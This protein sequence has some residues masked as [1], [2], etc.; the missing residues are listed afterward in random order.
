LVC[1]GPVSEPDKI[2][3]LKAADI[4][5]NPMFAGSGTNIKM[6]DFMALGLPTVV[7]ATGAR[8]IDPGS[9]PAFLQVGDRAQDV[10]E[11]IATLKNDPRRRQTM[12]KA[13]REWA[14]TGYAWE[15]IS[16]HLGAM[17][18]QRAKL[19][20]Q[21]RPWFSVVIP[22]FDRHAQLDQ[23]M[24]R[25][26]AQVERDFEVV[27]VD[28]S[29]DPWPGRDRPFN[30]P[31]TYFHTP[32]KGAVRA[33]NTGAALATGKILA[34][35]DDDCQPRPEW[36]VNAR[37]YFD[38]QAVVGVEGRVESDRLGDPDFR[39]VTNVGFTGM[40]FMT[41]NL[42]VRNAVF[43]LAGGFDLQFD[44][45]HFREDTDL[46]WRLQTYGQVPYGDDVVVFH[47]AQPRKI[48]RESM[49]A[50]AA[51]F[52]KDARLYRKHPEKYRDLFFCERHFDTY[53]G[54]AQNLLQGFQ[55]TGQTPPDWILRH[56]SA[57][58]GPVTG[59]PQS[60]PEDGHTPECPDR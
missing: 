30:M 27:I 53:P 55:E 5:V 43:Q 20:G 6:F 24:T 56:L 42:L 21:P 14:A 13:A 10:I 8:G 36:L 40:G 16:P 31:V 58:T 12:A 1:P 3:W 17:L 7:T 49:D 22:T 15:R 41:A 11:G 39:P 33:R 51:F 19:A 52:R 44:R 26:T 47:P 34:F 48:A 28:Q 38:H 54:F 32:V 60:P 46:G 45:P 4:A 2:R 29:Q 35:T 9:G 18:H 37:R 23:L 25:L 50:R 59:H 57:N